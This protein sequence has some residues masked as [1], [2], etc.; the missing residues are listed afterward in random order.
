MRDPTAPAVGSMRQMVLEQAGAEFRLQEIPLPQ[1]GPGQVLLAVSACAVCDID[2]YIHVGDLPGQHFPLVPGHE[3]VGQV[4]ATGEGVAFVTGQRVGL[5]WQGGA[6]G[7]CIYCRESLEHL[8]E[9]ARYI[10]RDLPGGYASHVLAD[11]RYCH[12]LSA[13]RVARNPFDADDGGWTE[14]AAMTPL[15][16]EGALAYRSYKA[17][18][19]A[20]RIGLYGFGTAAQL[21]CQ[22]AKADGRKVYA[23]TR[24]GG[25][26][27]L[28]MARQLGADWTGTMKQVPPELLDA[29]VMLQPTVELVPH[30]LSIVRRNGML[31]FLGMHASRVPAF[32]YDLF[33]DEH[34]LHSIARCS[35]AERE[36]FLARCA[37][38]TLQTRIKTYP[39][40]EVNEALRER[41][42]THHG[43][44]V[45]VM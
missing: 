1:P 33:R 10:G 3:I 29:V 39:F 8:C 35:H 45:L 38:Q 22:L 43:E 6:C 25:E 4:Q 32:P 21:I 37:R 18:G 11:A 30:A 24:E 23:L 27:L 15:L 42:N 2:P 17:C 36:E 41:R 13:V 5:A 34:S 12:D 19:K 14:E 31:V 20:E 7:L 26:P 28:E 44:T 40:T 9:D 16:C